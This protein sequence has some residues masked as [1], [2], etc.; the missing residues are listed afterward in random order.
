MV[1][2]EK[3]FD[4]RENILGRNTDFAFDFCHNYVSLPNSRRLPL[5]ATRREFEVKI[6]SNSSSMTIWQSSSPS[7]ERTLV[8]Y[9]ASFEICRLEPVKLLAVLP[10][11][12]KNGSRLGEIAASRILGNLHTLR[13][14]PSEYSETFTLRKTKGSPRLRTIKTLYKSTP[15]ADLNL[16]LKTY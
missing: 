16:T 4:D 9:R 13:K 6:C 2:I 15:A 12:Q 10:E 11:L 3:L 14:M 7:V 1:R 5:R 8:L